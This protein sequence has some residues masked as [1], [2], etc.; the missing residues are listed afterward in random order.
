MPRGFSCLGSPEGADGRY[1]TPP[2]SELQRLMWTKSGSSNRLD[3]VQPR[4]YIGDMYAAKDKRTLQV[5]RITHV[6]NAADG[7]YSVSTG[8]SFYRDTKIT[9]HGVEA[10]DMPSFDLSPF[11][12]PAANF[13]K[14]A[15]SSPTGKVF[16]H[17]A[18]GISRSSTLVLAYLMIH[19]N[20]TLVDAIKAVSA[21]RNISPNSGFLEQ[22]R[23]LDQK[24]YC[25]G[26]S[27]SWSTNGRT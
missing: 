18:M 16:V 4:I 6:L 25:Q 22:L 8:P 23:A 10:F 14:N 2:A 17:C 20:M 12:Y 26:S 15:L 5:H 21:N 1:E 24:L 3:E 19:E 7:K 11:F 27:R 9:Y 13:I